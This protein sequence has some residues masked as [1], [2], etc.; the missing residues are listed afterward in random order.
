MGQVTF[1]VWVA[2]MG[3]AGSNSWVSPNSES[4]FSKTHTGKQ[5]CLQVSGLIL[6]ASFCII[7][8]PNMLVDLSGNRKANRK[9][10]TSGLATSPAQ[11]SMANLGK[12][13]V[14]LCP[15]VLGGPTLITDLCYL[16]LPWPLTPCSWL[17]DVECHIGSEREL[18]A[19][20]I[21]PTVR[22]LRAWPSYLE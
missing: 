5:G 11:H 20:E 10:Q 17:W 18:S 22:D 9:S 7:A 12:W 6:K 8:V 21:L 19:R 13:L 1:G 4:F 15:R 16:G 2:E 3:V 14:G